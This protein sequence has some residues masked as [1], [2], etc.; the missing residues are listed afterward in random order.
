M[1]FFVSIDRPDDPM[2]EKSHGDEVEEHEP[3]PI[4]RSTL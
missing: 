3:V 1:K 2:D 4:W